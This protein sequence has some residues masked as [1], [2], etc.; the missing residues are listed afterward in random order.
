MR[1]AASGFGSSLLMLGFGRYL[2][3]SG[4][5]HATG[6]YTRE[7]TQWVFLGDPTG[8]E[9]GEERGRRE[10]CPET[11]EGLGGGST[12]FSSSLQSLAM[13]EQQPAT[14]KKEDVRRKKSKRRG[15]RLPLF[16]PAK[17]RR[18]VPSLFLFGRPRDGLKPFLPLGLQTGPHE[19]PSHSSGRPMTARQPC[20]G[21]KRGRQSHPRSKDATSP[22]PTIWLCAAASGTLHAQLTPP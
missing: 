5:R 2:S 13:E 6:S 11:E 7:H 1:E 8:L 22:P 9:E 3:W 21:E 14:D 12:S 10:A 15:S 19:T 18:L 16:F 20:E 4:R 17:R